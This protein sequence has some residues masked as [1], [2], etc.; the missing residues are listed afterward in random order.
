MPILQVSDLKKIYTTRFGGQQ[1]QAL[2]SVNFAVEPEI[3]R[4]SCRE[5]VCLYV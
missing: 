3:G 4:A 2:T 1:V 5:R